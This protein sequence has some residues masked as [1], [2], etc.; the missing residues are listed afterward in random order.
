MAAA[1]QY[2]SGF[3]QL[4]N[5]YIDVQRQMTYATSVAL[6]KT[7]AA[8]KDAINKDILARFDRPTPYTQ[9]ALRIQ[10]A[11]RDS[12]TA[13][14]NFKDAAGKGISADRYLGPQVYGGGRHQKRSEHALQSVGMSVGQY[15]V[16]A[17]G[18]EL[19]AYGNVSR[20]QTIRV[21]SYLQAFGEQGYR[22][23]ATAK[24]RARTAKLGKSAGG[25]RKIGGVQYFVSRGRGSMSGNREQHL[26]AGVWRKTGTHGSDVKPVFIFTGPPTYTPLLP[27]YETAEEVFG[28]EFDAQYGTALEAAI[29]TA[30]AR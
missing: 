13:H 11:T 1:I 27:F 10:R 3:S 7:A 5:L 17:A 12:L 28:E 6:N 14:V 23:N 18:A 30:R 2:V 8:V 24:S 20:G 4:P 9:N 29:R 26:P 25:F 21:L 19:D 15:M 22:A 16:P